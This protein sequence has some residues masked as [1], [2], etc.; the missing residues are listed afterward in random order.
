MTLPCSSGPKCS[1]AGDG[2]GEGGR[3]AE[4][5]TKDKQKKKRLRQNLRSESDKHSLGVTV[6]LLQKPASC[7]YTV[8]MV[9][10]PMCVY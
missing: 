9:S 1:A 5:S 2:G 7:L 3:F 8:C 6:A 4:S 10:Q